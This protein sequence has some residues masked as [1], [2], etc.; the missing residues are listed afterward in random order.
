MKAVILAGGEGTRLRPLS[1]HTPKSMVPILN[2]PF[3]DHVIDHL[4]QHSITDLVLTLHYLP[5]RVRSYFGDGWDSG[6][7]LTYALEEAPLG[8]AGAV[9][10]VEN[11]LEDSFLVINGDI[12]TDLDIRAAIQF[13]RAKKSQATIVLTSVDDPAAYG[14][15]QMDQARRVTSFLEKPTGYHGNRAWVNAGTYILEPGILQYIPP[16]EHYMFERGLFP[17]L[18]EMGIPVYGYES[19]DYWIDVGTINNYTKVHKDLLTGIAKVAMPRAAYGCVMIGSNCQVES[20][21]I[22]EGPVILGDLC[23]IE[24]N[25]RV[26]G[27]TVIGSG[28]V[29]R[30]G[31]TILEAV[32][33][34]GVSVGSRSVLKYCVI[35]S[36][37]NIGDDVIIEKGCVIGDASDIL[38]GVVLASG[39]I[40]EP[41]SCVNADAAQGKF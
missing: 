10:A 35:G 15:V 16:G 4:R 39:T 37:V 38:S 8:T 41:G 19:S 32:L 29:V 21:A 5:D 22:L 7:N 20:T 6:V 33:W 18:L 11:L 23:I 30:T 40:V 27:P 26:Y 36:N 28:C 1:Y 31:A 13:H 12:L 14:V 25:A 2:R 17:A 34:E 24:E 9:K 3:L